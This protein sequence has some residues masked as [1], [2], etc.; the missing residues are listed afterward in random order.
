MKQKY[1]Q[2]VSN[3]TI[4]NSRLATI[5]KEYNI[6]AAYQL[7]SQIVYVLKRKSWFARF[8]NNIF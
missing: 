4:S 2:I 7:C 1:T 5:E 3:G 8:I 6:I